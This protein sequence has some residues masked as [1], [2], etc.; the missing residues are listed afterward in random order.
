MTSRFRASYCPLLTR[1]SV[2]WNVDSVILRPLRPG[3][4]FRVGT[5]RPKSRPAIVDFWTPP[6]LGLVL[7]VAAGEEEAGAAT[8]IVVVAEAEAM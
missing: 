7:D 3:L 1:S 6:V 8:V 4:N 2:T 5:Q